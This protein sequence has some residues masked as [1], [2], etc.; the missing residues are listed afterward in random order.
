MAEELKP[1]RYLVDGMSG[2]LKTYRGSCHC[3]AYVYEAKMPHVFKVLECNCSSCYKKGALWVVPEP[4]N[5]RFVKG[6]HNTLANYTFG[7]KT[8]NHKFCP[9]CGVQ[10][11]FVG[12]ATLPKPGEEP[13]MGANV[14]SFQHGQ[15]VDVW[16][17]L[18]FYAD[19]KEFRGPYK[20]PKFTGPEPKAVIEGGKVYTGSC[21]CGAVKVALKTKPLD[22][23]ST[24]TIMECNCSI[25]NRMGY[26]WLYPQK[27]QVEI[28]GEENL[29]YYKFGTELAEKSFCKTCG[30]S[31]HNNIPPI[32][33]EELNKLP[34]GVREFIKGGLSLTPINLR[35]FNDL[36]VGNL[37][38]KQVDG[39]NRPPLY[40]EP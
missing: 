38:V 28:E 40:V 26:V 23:T 6:D 19:N 32:S 39:Y 10:L 8:I 14:R 35:V 34:E 15:G 29:A 11:L 2:D 13:R 18:K 21:H 17:I 20:T 31:I 5:I 3:G 22:K 24:E 37:N 36:D 25:C 4:G 27:D 33:E 9:N 16:N 7:E 1:Y 30:I 12:D